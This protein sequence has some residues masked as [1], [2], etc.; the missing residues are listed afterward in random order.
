DAPS[1]TSTS[2]L[3]L[4]DALP[5]LEGS[6]R[7]ERVGRQ[8]GLGD[9]QQNVLVGGRDAAFGD[10]A[11]VLVEQLGAL[12]LFTGDEARVAGVGDVHATQHL[13]NDHLDVLVVDLHTLQAVNVLHFI[14]DV[15]S[16]TLN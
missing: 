10:H 5:I 14:N 6:R 13:A 11:I 15:R 2:P 4:H 12:D 1:R 7:N 16:Q 9:A 3:S 8:R